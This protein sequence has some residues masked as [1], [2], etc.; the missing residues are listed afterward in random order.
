MISQTRIA[1]PIMQNNKEDILKTAKDYIRNGADFLEL[2]IDV[3]TDATPEMIKKIVEDISFP[4][5]ATNRAQNEGGYFLGSER[6]KINILK[7]CCNLKYVEYVDIELQTDPCLRNYI[8]SKCND[9]KVK[10]IIS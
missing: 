6:E 5:I 10:T 7:S 8:L 1:I 3:I 2:R 4:I 9:A